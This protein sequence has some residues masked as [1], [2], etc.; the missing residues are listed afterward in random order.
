MLDGWGMR[1]NA[2][3]KWRE[4]QRSISGWPKTKDPTKSKLINK[5]SR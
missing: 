3:T 5:I 4:Q 1:F 2:T